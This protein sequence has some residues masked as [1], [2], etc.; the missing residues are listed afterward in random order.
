MAKEKDMYETFDSAGGPTIPEKCKS[1][2]DHADSSGLDSVH[3][4]SGVEHGAIPTMPQ[5]KG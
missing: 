3:G 2:M 1:D 4:G 5:K